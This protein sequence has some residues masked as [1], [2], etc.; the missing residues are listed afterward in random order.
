MRLLLI[1]DKDTDV[2]RQITEIFEEGDY[3]V[4]APQSVDAVL[5]DVLKR[6]VKVIV[7]GSEFDDMPAKELIPLLKSCKRDLT[8]ILISDEESLPL[9]RKFRREGIFYHALKPINREDR[10]E[11]RQVVKCA[12]E[13]SSDRLWSA[14]L[15]Q[16]N[17]GE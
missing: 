5:R 1:A 9:L 17:H 13:N 10:D 12:F 2:R 15:S 7:L 14:R 6:D 3:Q 11:L 8:I 16:N 4:I